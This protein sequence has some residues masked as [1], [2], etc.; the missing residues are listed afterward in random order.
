MTTIVI[1]LPLLVLLIAV[2]NHATWP[3]GR[4]RPRDG[5]G[6]GRAAEVSVLIPA[7]NEVAN[8]EP[9][10]RSLQRQTTP[11]AEIIVYDDASTDGTGALL[12]RL[13][14][15]VPELVVLE[16]RGLPPGWVGKPHACHQLALAARQPNLLFIDADVQL[17]PTGI[18]RLC[19]VRDD[20]SAAAVTAV[21]R[22]KVVSPLERLV[23]PLLHLTY[24]AWLPLALVWRSRDPRLLAANGQLLLV[25][26]DAHDRIGGFASVKDAIV[27]DMAFCRRLKQSGLRVVFADGQLMAQC[28]MYRSAAEVW[29]GFSKNIY[30]GVGARPGR[31]LFALAINLAAFVLPL[32]A[33]A[34]PGLVP[35]NVA[36]IGAVAALSTTALATIR[37]RYPPSTVVLLPVGVVLLT[38]IGLNS[39]RWHL[40]GRIRWRDRVYG[41][42]LSS[43]EIIP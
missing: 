13:K 18:E 31:L 28:R 15:E 25:S 9:L 3:R 23:V 12:D 36:V 41:S 42:A 1:G 6:A 8:L 24:L 32:A 11:A 4:M 38:F 14:A 40:K 30:L 19:S 17:L 7:R 5:L 22:Q 21:P 34:W 2:V 35:T 29:S 20:L 16:G 37:H 26:R 10:I 43:Q 33:L 27:D 39:F